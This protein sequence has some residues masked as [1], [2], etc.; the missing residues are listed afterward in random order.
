MEALVKRK[1]D[2]MG[3]IS[4]PTEFRKE[5]GWAEG[6][7]V[8][9]Y[10]VKNILFMELTGKRQDPTCVFCGKP[11]SKMRINASDICGEC[12]EKVKGITHV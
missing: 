6:D 10:R 4:L 3:R 9:I 2:E 1:I 11:E 5:Y 7:T 8:S 12:L